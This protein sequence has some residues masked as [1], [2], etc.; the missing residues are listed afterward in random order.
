M[1]MRY[2]HL[3]LSHLRAGIDALEQR[4]TRQTGE[5]ELSTDFRVTLESR[6]F[7]ENA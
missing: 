5:P 3:A 6:D 2:A 7:P 1:T 4:N